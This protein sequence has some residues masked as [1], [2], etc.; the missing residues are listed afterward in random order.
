MNIKSVVSPLGE[1]ASSLGI[2]MSFRALAGWS[3]E[4]V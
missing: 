1:K 3:M 4:C 2:F